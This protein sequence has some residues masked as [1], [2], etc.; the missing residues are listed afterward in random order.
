MKHAAILLV[1]TVVSISATAAGSD[2]VRRETASIRMPDGVTLAADIVRSDAAGPSPAILVMT[3]YGRAERFSPNAVKAFTASGVVLVLVDVRGS[4]ASQGV[5]PVIFS[6]E[7]RGD[8]AGILAWIASQSWSNGRVVV[9]GVSYDGNLAALALASESPALAAVVP[10]FVD[11]DTYGDLAFP[12]GMRNEMLLREWGALTEAHDHG[13]PCLLAAS[14]C[15][16]AADLTP[17]AEDGDRRM[18]R[19]A[20][21]EHQRNWSPYRDTFGIAFSDDVTPSGR[22]LDEGSLSGVLPR[23]A[24]SR[25]PVQLWGSWFD[26]A[27][28]DGALRWFEAAPDAPLELFLGGWT[29]GGGGRVDPLLPASARSE[30]GAPVP[31]QEFLGFV[32]RA[33][34]APQGIRR[35]ITYYTAGA[36]VW[37]STPTWP[38]KGLSPTRWHLSAGGLLGTMPDADAGG[39][40]RY[41]V[42][43]AATTGKSNRWT[44]QLGGG[45][46]DYGD[47]RLA[48]ARLLTYTSA[49]LEEDVEITG[50]PSVSLGMSA[51]HPDG[52]VIAYLEAVRPDGGVVYL[53]EGRRRL[54]LRNGFRRS[55]AAPVEPGAR[56]DLRIDLHAVSAVV[57]RGHR[58][59]LAIAGADADTFARSPATG[60]PVYTFHRGPESR[61]FLEIPQAPWRQEAA[62]GP[63]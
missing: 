60:D 44:T 28:A 45:P 27:T 18:L 23:L 21:L 35:R 30:Q 15:E 10:R 47:R 29:H 13:L 1:A 4:G 57:P 17:L 8:I 5:F 24:A 51:T 14:A 25:T 32:K 6:R 48:D 50:T 53:S 52:A 20:L 40:D 62:P 43:F 38:P 46:V 2:P 49:P 16:G 58:L 63:K 41:K 7:E 56:L 33:L 39:A 59:Q 22:R 31:A 9:T 37:R 36:G 3:R 12:G 19:R 11:L 26:A 42:D 61:S 55:D 34:E 54:A